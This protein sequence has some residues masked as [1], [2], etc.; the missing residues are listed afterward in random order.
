[1]LTKNASN[2]LHKVAED[3]TVYGFAPGTISH[4][5]PRTVDPESVAAHDMFTYKPTVKNDNS[6]KGKAAKLGRKILG[7]P[8]KEYTYTKS[9]MPFYANAA[10]HRNEL[11]TMLASDTVDTDAMANWLTDDPN[12]ATMRRNHYAGVSD[13]DWTKVFKQMSPKH[14]ANMYNIKA[15]M[16]RGSG[17]APAVGGAAYFDPP[18][19]KG[20]IHTNR[21]ALQQIKNGAPAKQNATHWSGNML[22]PYTLD[23]P[24]IYQHE[25]IHAEQ[26]GRDILN[27]PWTN[28]NKAQLL[29]HDGISQLLVGVDPYSIKTAE[30]R[31]ATAS[32]NR[33]VYALSRMLNKAD[34][35]DKKWAQFDKNKLMYV[36]DNFKELPKSREEFIQRM[37]WLSD[38]PEIAL[39]LG[40]G[41][42]G[43][44]YRK[45]LEMMNKGHRRNT[46][47]LNSEWV[48][49]AAIPGEAQKA[50]DA[51]DD[52]WFLAN[53]NNN[54][55]NKT[56]LNTY[57]LSPIVPA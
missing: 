13:K 24:V 19:A 2:V 8:D 20:S 25:G 32:V 54:I 10:K 33:G 4:N 52:G 43:V 7:T 22:Y 45:E 29:G 36:R 21:G 26:N 38:N 34:L 50:L 37:Q 28:K 46:D 35:N 53:K 11:N 14:R 51:F 17:L 42:R 1:M 9:N 55:M 41:A 12:Y 56:G 6:I 39:L 40:E 57:G 48:H 27:A 18:W 5:P 3:K 31:Q 30:T 49:D 16:V 47:Q 44:S 15:P 23:L